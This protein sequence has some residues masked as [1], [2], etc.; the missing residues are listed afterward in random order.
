MTMKLTRRAFNGCIAASG[1]GGLACVCSAQATKPQP[2][3]GCILPVNRAGYYLD[4]STRPR[5]YITGQ[6]P[7]VSKSGDKDFDFA[8]AQTLARIS[9]VFNVLPGFAYYEDVEAQ[10]AYATAVVKLKN[11][12]GTVLF[13]QNLLRTVLAGKESPDV[14]VAAVCAHEFGHILQFKYGLDKVVSEGQKTVKRVELQAD[15][16]AG[17][18]AGVR[19]RERPSFPAA[20]FAMTQFNNGDQQVTHQG[21]HG[22]PDERAQA[23]GQGFEAS[24]S[25]NLTIS[26]ALQASTRYVMSF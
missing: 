4:R 6:E 19:K 24:F 17:Y 5:L 8:L 13:G 15:Y 1:L 11:A 3:F 16:L 23:V 9:E 26:A 20:V 21:H 18:F 25:L 2:I 22:T 14:A 10:N 12:D 7:I